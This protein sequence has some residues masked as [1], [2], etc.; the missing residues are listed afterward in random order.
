MWP[1]GVNGNTTS[2]CAALQYTRALFEGRELEDACAQ[3]GDGSESHRVSC[4]C[5]ETNVINGNQKQF[6]YGPLLFIFIILFLNTLLI[7]IRMM[8]SVFCKWDFNLKVVFL[9]NGCN[10]SL[11]TSHW[12]MIVSTDR[13]FSQQIYQSMKSTGGTTNISI[14]GSLS[15]EPAGTIPNPGRNLNGTQ[16]SLMCY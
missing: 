15:D 9:W 4:Q 1:R 5:E 7:R 3:Y 10:H 16:P 12:S 2:L 6:F 11:V 14:Q 8:K 13:P